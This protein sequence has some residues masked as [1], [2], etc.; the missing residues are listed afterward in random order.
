MPSTC[1]LCET[2]NPDSAWECEVCGKRILSSGVSVPPIDRL[3]GL[4]ST[5]LDPGPADGASI[6]LMPEVELTRHEGLDLAVEIEPLPVERAELGPAEPLQPF[7][8]PGL[9]ALDT[10]RE[11]D[12]LPPTVYSDENPTCVWCGS[13]AP[14]AVCDACGRRRTRGRGSELDKL[15]QGA[16]SPEGGQRLDPITMLCPACFTRVPREAR[17]P[18]CRAPLPPQD[19]Y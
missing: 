16:G 13:P 8:T 1:P 3:D 11:P 2:L 4:E 19:L 15:R 5:V 12:G 14:R 7:W 18:E 10:G 17:C 9:D 6:G